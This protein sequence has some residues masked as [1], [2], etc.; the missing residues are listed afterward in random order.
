MQL[1][2]DREAAAALRASAAAFE[3]AKRKGYV[4][5]GEDGRYQ[6]HE[7]FDMLEEPK[8]VYHPEQLRLA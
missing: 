1:K 3:R 6:T 2:L 5:I 4:W 8:V 7:Q